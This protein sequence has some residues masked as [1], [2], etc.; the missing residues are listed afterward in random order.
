MTKTDIILNYLKDGNYI[1]DEKAVELCRS[2]RLSSIIHELRHRHGLNI[3]DR[4]IEL[5][6]G[7]KFK[8]Y[9][10]VNENVL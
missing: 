10:L 3:Q 7:Y 6:N 2:Y 9:Y 5:D 4:W 8:E 1:S